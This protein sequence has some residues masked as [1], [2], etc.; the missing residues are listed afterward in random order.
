VQDDKSSH[1]PVEKE[2]AAFGRWLRRSR[3]TSFLIESKVVKKIQFSLI[4]SLRV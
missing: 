1:Y 4:A 2:R 3:I